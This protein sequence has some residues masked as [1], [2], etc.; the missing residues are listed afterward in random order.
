LP[1]LTDAQRAQL[2]ALRATYQA[3]LP[4]KVEAVAAAAG[5]L[6]AAGDDVANLQRFYDL[7]HKLAGS[8][9][10]YG[11]D[12]VGGAAS[13]LEEWALAGLATGL[14]EPRRRELP[15]LVAA[16]QAALTT[17]PCSAAGASRA[18]DP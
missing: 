6:Q 12:G 3:E 11:F 14:S 2:D 7:I 18:P 5:P 15:L 13:T 17:S 10:V 16:L 1:R 4:Q 9:A 8:A